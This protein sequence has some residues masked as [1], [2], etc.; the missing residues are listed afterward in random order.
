MR[1]VID[2]QG[3]Q[4]ESRF[5]GIGRYSLSWAKAIARNRG[6]HEILLVLNGGFQESI[7]PIQNA[8]EGLLEPHDITIWHGVLP[9]R[10]LFSG[11]DWRRLASEQM[12]ACFLKSLAPDAVLISSFFEGYVDDVTASIDSTPPAPLTGVILY[13]LIPLLNPEKYLAHPVFRV[14]YKR[15]LA[16]FKQADLFLAISESARQEGIEQ[17]GIAP[18][19]AVNI[20]AA[21][22]PT[23]TSRSVAP[24]LAAQL[25]TRMGID[26]PFVMYTGGTDERKN[27]RRLIIAFSRLPAVV[28]DA[29]QLVL[30][31]RLPTGDRE[32]LTSLALSSGMPAEGMVITGYVSDDEL[33]DLYNLCIG[34]VCPSWHEGFGLPVLEAMACGAP[35]ICSNTSSLPEVMDRADAQFDPMNVDDIRERLLRLL[36]DPDYR[37]DLSRYGQARAPEFSWDACATTTLSALEERFEGHATVRPDWRSVQNA[38]QAAQR[39]LIESIASLPARTDE[40]SDKDLL[41]VAKGIHANRRRALGTHRASVIPDTGISWRIE[42]PFDSSYSLALLNRETARAL[43]QLGHD[44]ALHSTEGPGDF[45]ADK[46]F[47]AQNPDLDTMHRK[48][49]VVRPEDTLVTSRNLYPPRVA[50]M[51]SQFN[52]L[53]HYAWEES[54]FPESWVEDFNEHLQAMTCLSEHVRKVMIDHGVTIPLLTSGCGVDHWLRVEPDAGFTPMGKSFRFLHVSSCFPRKGADCLLAAFAATFS[55]QDDV[56]LIIKTFQNPHNHIA[57]ALA[58]ARSVRDDFPDVVLIE[59]DWSEARLQALYQSCHVLV[60]PSRAEGFGL[61]MAEAMLSGLAVITTG[62]GGQLAFCDPDTAWLIDYHFA[63]AQTHFNLHDSVWAEPDQ[64]DLARIMREVFTLD[65][66]V[67]RVKVEL[68][69]TRLMEGF[70]W[71]QVANR[72]VDSVRQAARDEPTPEPRIGWISSW[73]A[74][75]GIADYSRHLVDA[76]PA[77]I[78]VFASRTSIVTEADGPGV[79]RC[80]NQDNVDDL[81]ELSAR[82]EASGIDTLIVQFNYGF[83]DFDHLARFLHDQ[84]DSNRCV[85]VILHAT[86]DPEHLRNKRLASLQSALARCDRLLV[87]SPADLNRLKALGL[88]ENVALFPHGIVDRDEPSAVPSATGD[89]FTIASYGFFLPHKGLPELLEAVAT[90]RAS[91]INLRLT[92]VNSE[93]PV[94]ESKQMI[95]AASARIDKLNLG[96]HVR[97]VTDFLPAEQSLSLLEEANLIVFPYQ[98][99]GESSSAAVRTGLGRPVVVTPLSIF[100]DVSTAVFKLPGCTTADI[101]TGIECLIKDIRQNTEQVQ[102]TGRHAKGWRDAHRH[103]RLGPRLHRTLIALQRHRTIIPETIITDSES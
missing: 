54:G 67:R 38:S 35:V 30:V 39:D 18:E 95:A 82:I 37:E 88:V 55:S 63:P 51:R 61:P 16:Q 52:L 99:T 6:H 103:S 43:A 20:S 91:G 75:C 62:W 48:A 59:E 33:V 86:V 36:T 9:V 49:G 79:E 92:M 14:H 60:A 102:L 24:D 78:S 96:S 97:L 11:N 40:P 15:K 93:Y 8:F 89:T 7:K 22:D 46:R 44:V 26:R 73:N 74:R 68:G 42:G 87:H 98:A 84:I 94:G 83:Y 1:I 90:L 53:H 12:R 31:G 85:V 23:F 45:P 69:R 81:R 57:A 70:Q 4:S 13:D 101:V 71:T 80:W 32:T 25:R 27:L 47:L 10:E 17:L 65:D 72:V 5:R 2:L 34:V 3:S 76:L 66:T 28:R 41:R 56:S 19:R 50:D 77:D 21:V 64:D 58:Q 100:D 29:A